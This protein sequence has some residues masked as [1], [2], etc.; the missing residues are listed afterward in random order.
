MNERELEHTIHTDLSRDDDYTGYLQLDRLLSAQA[1]LSDPPHHDEML[2]IIQHQVAELWIKL[3]IHEIG[4][5]IQHIR[6][7]RLAPAVKNLARVRHIQNQLYNQWKVLD[8]LTPSEYAEF[9]H[10]F[11]KASGFQ[12]AQYR[13]LEFILGN[14]SRATMRVYEH[15]PDWYARLQRALESPSLY[16][17]FLMHLA[18]QGMAVPEHVLDRDFCEVRDEDP[19][20]VGVL[21]EIY[22]DRSAHWQ[23]YEACEALMDISNNFQFWRFHHMKTVERIIGH[24]RGTGGSSGVMFL[25]KALDIEF[26][27]ELLK[28]RTEIGADEED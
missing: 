14:K 6:D 22:E 19:A 1:P 17:E 18:R 20:V 8:T 3:L 13:I 24:K 4:G 10:V 15:Q 28:V 12:S 7:D 11:G 2:F 9:R 26:F 23:Q 27:P 21:R 16:E 25:K 5:A